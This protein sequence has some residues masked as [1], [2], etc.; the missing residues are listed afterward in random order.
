M[1]RPREP[2]ELEEANERFRVACA[3]G[4]VQ[5]VLE[6]LDVEG[7]DPNFML[8]GKKE[9]PLVLACRRRH[10][11]S[12]WDTALGIVSLLLKRVDM[13]KLSQEV[14]DYCLHVAVR[15]SSVEVVRLLCE[16]FKALPAS[17]LKSCCARID[18][19]A[20][21]VAAYFV[22][23][24]NL[25]PDWD[26]KL[27]DDFADTFANALF[28]ACCMSTDDV[29]A[30]LQK[31]KFYLR[32]GFSVFSEKSGNGSA[33]S[34][35]TYVM[36][37]CRNHF[38]GA[39]IIRLL[40][41]Q[42]KGPLYDEKTKD[43]RGRTA[44]QYACMFGNRDIV[45]TVLEFSPTVRSCFKIEWVY[46][47]SCDP[48]GVLQAVTDAERIDARLP[49]PERVAKRRACCKNAFWAFFRTGVPV[50]SFQE[51]QELLEANNRIDLQE[52]LTNEAETFRD[53]KSGDTLLHMAAAE[54]NM[55][56][57][58]D[59]MSEKCNP[60]VPSLDSTLPVDV[61]ATD[62]M[63]TTLLNYM[64]VNVR[65]LHTLTWR[66][67]LFHMR[68]LALLLIVNRYCREKRLRV[69]LP[70]DIVN[71]ILELMDRTK[72]RAC[73]GYRIFSMGQDHGALV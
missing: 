3:S 25:I 64:R 18:Y 17:F 60:F 50:K 57:L 19:G 30:A 49:F 48:L 12:E 45:E 58:K 10:W 1:K 5:S 63:R 67:P 46:P 23:C 13:S 20:A 8:H 21:A 15:R 36:G 73:E 11:Q 28:L 32:V 43:S 26:E 51:L 72:L 33:T 41:S 29:V 42:A 22:D 6:L 38:G 31:S 66:G 54:G 27:S 71:V 39:K 9:S 37:A 65:C 70:K 24:T 40:L 59:L 62:E 68:A 52:V 69:K 2:R 53:P 14:K 55:E 16:T 4:S 44:F 47:N 35:V 34:N 56:A 61:A 7:A